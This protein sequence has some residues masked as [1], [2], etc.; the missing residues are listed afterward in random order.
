MPVSTPNMQF[1]PIPFSSHETRVGNVYQVYHRNNTVCWYN[2][3]MCYSELGIGAVQ[4]RRWV[5]GPLVSFTTTITYIIS[6]KTMKR[7][8]KIS[9]EYFL[10]WVLILAAYFIYHHQPAL[11]G[12]NCD[13]FVRNTSI[14]EIRPFEIPLAC[15]SSGHAYHVIMTKFGEWAI[16]TFSM[17]RL[18]I[19]TDLIKI[20]LPRFAISWFLTLSPILTENWF[21]CYGDQRVEMMQKFHIYAYINPLQLGR[22]SLLIP[23][24]K[25]LCFGW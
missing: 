23:I 7:D 8:S 18:H 22:R 3:C 14:G 10:I 2:V 13:A 5:P 17:H 11:D 15:T 20:Y 1:Q 16:P 9:I 21:H 24:G 19:T 12:Q 4:T 6:N 25:P